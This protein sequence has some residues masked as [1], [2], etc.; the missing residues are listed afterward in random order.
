[1]FHTLEYLVVLHIYMLVLD[2]NMTK[3]DLKVEKCSM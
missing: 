1:M 2:E 3:L